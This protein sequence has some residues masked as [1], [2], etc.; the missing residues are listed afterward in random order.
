M[1]DVG[2]VVMRSK[3]FPFGSFHIQILCRQRGSQ[4]LPIAKQ[5]GLVIKA[6]VIHPVFPS[7][8]WGCL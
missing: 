2:S 6:T 4:K 8:F 1:S 3:C 5:E 7:E